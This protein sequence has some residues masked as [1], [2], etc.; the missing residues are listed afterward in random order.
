MTDVGFGR[1]EPAEPD[2]VGVGAERL[3]ERR[4][5]DR[6]ADGGART[7]CFD[8]ADRPRVDPGHRER[9]LDDVGVSVDTRREEPDL[10]VAVVVDG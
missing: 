2:G 1:T 3:G 9:F 8:Q 10:P 6:V 7:V 5:F 4:D